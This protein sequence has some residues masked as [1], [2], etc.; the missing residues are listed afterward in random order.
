M[1]GAKLDLVKET[2]HFVITQLLKED[3]FGIVVY[4]TFICIILL[5]SVMMI[6][7]KPTYS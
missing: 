5:L 6:P 7:W 4:L 3:R 2:L 1:A